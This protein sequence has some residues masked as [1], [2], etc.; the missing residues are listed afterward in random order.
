MRAAKRAA[1]RLAILLVPVAAVGTLVWLARQSL[2]RPAGSADDFADLRIER[3]T[4]PDEKN[5]R[6]V[7]ERAGE[8]LESGKPTFDWYQL[9]GWLGWGDWNAGMASTGLVV[10]AEARACLV[11][12]LRTCE[13]YAGM[14]KPE[15]GGGFY[16]SRAYRLSYAW[17][18][19]FED[20]LHKGDF[21]EAYAGLLTG[22]R[23]V[24]M[25]LGGASDCGDLLVTSLWFG[26]VNGA[27]ERLLHSEGC[28]DEWLA[29]LARRWPRAELVEAVGV[30][31]LKGEF[32]SCARGIDSGDTI[33]WALAPSGGADSMYLRAMRSRVS[34][35]PTKELVAGE[36]RRH[37]AAL[38]ARHLEVAH[39]E[40]AG[41]SSA[42]KAVMSFARPNAGG[43]VVAT[44][45]TYI[46]GHHA[47]RALALQNG[48]EC[49]RALLA[50]ERYRRKTGVYPETLAALVP[51][52]L[53]AVPRD[54]YSGGELHY[55]REREL[56]WAEGENVRDDGGEPRGTVGRS[57]YRTPQVRYAADMVYPVSEKACRE[58]AAQGFSARRR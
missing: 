31:T 33:R 42:V 3:R 37:V 58:A 1:L 41:E 27:C 40:R 43:R 57:C 18:L 21:G 29:E 30:R 28:R 5:L 6:V 49:L 26:R 50:C 8:C 16:Q 53:G 11:E 47:S 12:G 54:T 55:S 32:W 17:C 56:L 14:D 24:E 2:A 38:E 39:F 36:V 9:N 52:Y 22:L 20:A 48:S 51:E 35:Q 34:A 7:M 25:L 4:V 15:D 44:Y 45:L 10:S 23:I 13:A 46:T 19:S